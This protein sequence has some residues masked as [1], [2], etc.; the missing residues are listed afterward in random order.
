MANIRI[1]DHSPIILQRLR[2]ILEPSGL[3]I[4]EETGDDREAVVWHAA[5]RCAQTCYR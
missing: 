1:V 3:P 4:A 2:A 5:K